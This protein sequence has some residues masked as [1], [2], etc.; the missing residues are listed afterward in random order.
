MEEIWKDIEG[1]EGY[2]QISNLARVKSL[3]RSIIRANGNIYNISEKFLNMGLNKDGYARVAL[4]KNSKQ[5]FMFI[6]RLVATYFIPNPDSK[7]EVNHKNGIKSDNSI[8]NLE[9]VSPSENVQHGYN[10][11]LS[12]IGEDRYNSKLTNSDIV[13]IRNSNLKQKELSEIYNVSQPVIS[14]IISGITW[15]HL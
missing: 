11:G 1:Y 9:W 2:Y 3:S 5:T 12:K 6:H 15:K 10:I 4:S 14:R 13:T 7:L 8:Q